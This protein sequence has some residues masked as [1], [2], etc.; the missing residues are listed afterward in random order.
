MDRYIGLSK[1][2]T[3]HL[4][5][6]GKTWFFLC[7]VTA[8]LRLH[9]YNINISTTAYLSQLLGQDIGLFP[10]STSNLITMSIEHRQTQSAHLPRAYYTK[11]RSA[12]QI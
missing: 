9:C 2:Q 3:E 8:M 1:V 5:H 10:P 7:I 6:I 4:I 12:K 11:G